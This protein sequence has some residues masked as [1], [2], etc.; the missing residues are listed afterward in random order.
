MSPPMRTCAGDEPHAWPLSGA[1]AFADPGAVHGA[2]GR[3]FTE[4]LAI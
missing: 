1:A 3:D 2:W 4:K